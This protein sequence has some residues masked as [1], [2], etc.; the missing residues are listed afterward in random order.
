MKKTYFKDYKE[1]NEDERFL[2]DN[3][4]DSLE[5]ESLADEEEDEFY[6]E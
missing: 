2:L 4:F 1:D 5:L 6:Q 3:P